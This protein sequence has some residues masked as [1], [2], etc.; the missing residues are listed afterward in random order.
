MG[1]GKPTSTVPD[2]TSF[3][4]VGDN[5]MRESAVLRRQADEISTTVSG[6]V[7]EFPRSGSE[8]DNKDRSSRRE[9]LTELELEQLC[10]AARKR[11]RWGHRDAT[12]ILIAY[13][14]GFGEPFGRNESSSFACHRTS[15]RRA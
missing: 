4:T 11:G 6:T 14:H 2:L 8:P 5:E 7:V 13:R 1:S 15:L 3:E 9:W 12:M 10:D